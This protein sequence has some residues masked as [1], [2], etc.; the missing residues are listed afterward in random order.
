[1]TKFQ[2]KKIIDDII[3][4]INNVFYLLEINCTRKEN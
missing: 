4:K 1:M 2:Y 3:N